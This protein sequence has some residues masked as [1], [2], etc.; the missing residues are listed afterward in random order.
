MKQLELQ[1]FINLSD[2]ICKALSDA[3]V[4]NASAEHMTLKERLHYELLLFA[5]FLANSDQNIEEKEKEIIRRYLKLT[6]DGKELFDKEKLTAAEALFG[7]E[8]PSVLKYAVLADAGDKIPNDPYHRQKAMVIYDTF[9]LF[10]QHIM[11]VQTREVSEKTISGYTA[12][13]QVME[14][15]IKDLAVW[16]AGSQK[17]YH[18][19]EPT[20]EDTETPEEKEK[21][22]EEL[23]EDLNALVGLEEVKHQVHTMVNLVRVQKMR[24]DMKMKTTDIS[25]HMVFLGNPGTGKTTVARKLAE[26]Y[27]YMGVLQKAGL[28]RGYVGQ[29]ATRVQ[30]VVAEAMGGVLFVDEA[31]ALT[32]GKGEG[33]FGQEAVDTLL[34]AMEDHRD[35]LIVIVA[36]YTDLMEEFLSSNPGLKSRF[37]NYIHFADY[38][39]E[40]LLAI[41]EMNL[42]SR[43]YH[44]TDAARE[45]A[46]R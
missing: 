20:I 26:I 29:T 36:G 45:A 33:D 43:E 44:M 37:S 6:D 40:E 22:L 30:E 8:V 46:F 24:E 13:M 15:F 23:L 5:G 27:K 10:G 11:A 39:A 1:E 12:A 2:E 18:P 32:V 14:K 25:K 9:K 34:K 4:G 7:H 41:L 38:S 16:Y 21:R 17:L 42:R 3:N 31:Y 19:V 35:E 28:V